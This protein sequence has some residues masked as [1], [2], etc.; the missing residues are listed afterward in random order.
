MGLLGKLFGSEKRN[1]RLAAWGKSVAITNLQQEAMWELWQ[2]MET[3]VIPRTDPLA[4]LSVEDRE[5]VLKI[6]GS[7]FRPT[8]FGG[9]DALRLVVFRDL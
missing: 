1:E 6:C 4:K 3:G 2:S 7:S 5:Y 8:E 9:V